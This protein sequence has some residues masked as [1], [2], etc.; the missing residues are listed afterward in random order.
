MDI[1]YCISL[2]SLMA[3]RCHIVAG[4]V[5][6][7]SF[8]LVIVSVTVTLVLEREYQ[9]DVHS[10][11]ELYNGHFLVLILMQFPDCLEDEMYLQQCSKVSRM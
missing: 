3:I 10:L 8:S 1:L 4:D 2:Q 9:I 6:V 11:Q 5:K 7:P